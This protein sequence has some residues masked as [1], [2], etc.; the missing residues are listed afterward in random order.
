MTITYCSKCGINWA[1]L[2]IEDV[3][4]DETYESCPLCKSDMYLGPGTD[5]VA[6]I[7]CPV[8][9]RIT[10]VET[11]QELNTVPAKLVYTNPEK[12]RVYD[13]TYEDWKA[14][15]EAAEDAYVEAAGKIPK[16]MIIRKHHYETI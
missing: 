10:N 15:D 12:K 6:Y 1:A 7:K 9:G 14:R 16:E 13:E 8:S 2:H 5:I 11:G 3:D 4:G